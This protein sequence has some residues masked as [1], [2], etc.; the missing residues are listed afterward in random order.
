V[1]LMA[2]SPQAFTLADFERMAEWSTRNGGW[3]PSVRVLT[4]FHRNSAKSTHRHSSAIGQL[5]PFMRK[6]TQVG[7][8]WSRDEQ[9]WLV[10]AAAAKKSTKRPL[11]ELGRQPE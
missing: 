11:K 5:R 9:T 2:M 4:K 6:K 10:V 8:D 3:L 7:N 1:R